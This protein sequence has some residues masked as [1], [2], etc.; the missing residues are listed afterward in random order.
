MTAVQ[1][2]GEHIARVIIDSKREMKGSETC[3]K[4]IYVFHC[5]HP[6]LIVVGLV[7]SHCICIWV[8][9]V[10]SLRTACS[11]G[12]YCSPVLCLGTNQRTPFPSSVAFYDSS[13]TVWA[14]SIFFVALLAKPNLVRNC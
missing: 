10:G 5:M 8:V 9:I 4:K 13:G 6:Y 1:T 14:A 12:D 2:E 7:F 11:I 3:G